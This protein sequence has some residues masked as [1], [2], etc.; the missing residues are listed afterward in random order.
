MRYQKLRHGTSSKSTRRIDM[1]F[2]SMDIPK[3]KTYS[4]DTIVKALV[5]REFKN[6]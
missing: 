5:I 2:E 1:D 4:T 6:L 3:L